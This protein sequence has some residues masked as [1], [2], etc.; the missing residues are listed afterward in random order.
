MNDGDEKG[1]IG[2]SKI[3]Q[4]AVALTSSNAVQEKFTLYD[5]VS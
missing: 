1:M 2:P 3:V 4:K 5:K